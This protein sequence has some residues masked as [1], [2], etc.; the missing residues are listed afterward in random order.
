C[1]TAP[2]PY[3]LAPSAR[4]SRNDVREYLAE[5]ARLYGFGAVAHVGAVQAIFC[6]K[7]VVEPDREIIFGGYLLRR[8]RVNSRIPRADRGSIG[9]GVKGRKKPA[10]RRIHRHR[11]RRKL[12]IARRRR[13]NR[14]HC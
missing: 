2:K 14:I 7:L 8:E 5:G 9:E 13:R 6:R 1:A 4:F 3:S 11:S 10:H 12:A